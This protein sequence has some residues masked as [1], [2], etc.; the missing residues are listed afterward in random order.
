MGRLAC[1]WLVVAGCIADRTVPCGDL[2]CPVG[3]VCTPG[4]CATEENA[5][6]CDAVPD[7]D[8]CTT[9]AREPGSC[10]GGACQPVVC[11]NGVREPGE[12]CDDA[13]LD[14]GDGC[15]ATC[16]S[17]ET[18]GNGVIDTGL[19]EQCDTG[20]AGLSS[21]GCSSRCQGELH[22]WQE[23]TPQAIAGRGGLAFGYDL[24]RG[25]SIAFGGY[26]ASSTL[27]DTWELKDL[28]WRQRLAPV[29]P[30]ARFYAALAYDPVSER[31]LLFGGV[32]SSQVWGDTWAWDGDTWV[33]LAPT[34]MP[35]ARWGA[36]MAPDYDRGRVVLFGGYGANGDL[37]DTWEWD[38]ADWKQVPITTP[39]PRRS[40]HA[41]AFDGVTRQVVM[42]GG[43]TLMGDTWTYDGARWL[44]RTTTTTPTIRTATRMAYD[45]RRRALVIFGGTDVS[46]GTRLGETWE[47]GS[48]WVKRTP[49]ASPPPRTE[50][51]MVWD[52]G[53]QRVLV[54]GGYTYTSQSVLYADLW[55]YDGTTWAQV[56]A[57]PPSPPP[58]T[59]HGF[60]YDPRRGRGLLFGGR[61]FFE[62][63]N[64]TWQW[65][66]VT[67]QLRSTSVAP[68][69]RYG[70]ATTYDPVRDRVLVFGGRND[71]AQTFDDLW[72]WDGSAWSTVTQTGQPPARSYPAAAYDV[73]RDRWVLFGGARA[74]S[75]P[76]S[77]LA[78]T[79][80]WDGTTWIQREPTISP[81]P[82]WGAVA[83]YDRARQRIV[84]FGGVAVD[85]ADL[86]D[87][88]E[89]DG[90]TWTEAPPQAS[91]PQGRHFQLMTYDPGR[92]SVFMF[93]GEARGGFH[94]EET[95]E[96]D[97][98][99]TPR[100]PV[101]A[102]FARSG[103]QMIY[104]AILRRL[105]VFGGRGRAD[106]LRDT[107]S[108]GY[109]AIS[110]SD[111]RCAIANIDAD[112]D[113]LA[114]CDDP[115]CWG[116]C[117]PLCMPGETCSPTAPH[118][119]DGE[120]QL[121]EDRLLCPADC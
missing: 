8:A 82:R 75:G 30:P 7:G 55:A 90:T 109:D 84:V 69:H 94:F 99:W 79:W 121:T 33:A 46:L 18:C 61:S 83:V 20:L 85:N 15:S 9:D 86:A 115:D 21:D 6:A 13:N 57:T 17:D 27:G 62:S 36:A 120:C 77:V 112:G 108:L 105:V 64:D 63:Y 32:G 59:D 4:G 73:A 114:T 78:D 95:W 111:E 87:T 19:G 5:Y 72:A 50:L 66:G 49:S 110:E 76:D 102:A 98:T 54:T 16:A 60:V 118:C 10:R 96:F 42:F 92:R 26:G 12:A 43:S 34:V 100:M 45:E 97:G 67:W 14:G 29:A 104:D 107:I 93:G 91:A 48:D 23:I 68:A 56:P 70:H 65:D 106:I 35:P 22:A 113:G 52:Q 39:P 103:G 89:W 119:G 117:A 58:R 44:P 81:P 71:M 1:V 11:G 51:G 37:N 80:E 101:D 25:V 38:G 24:K 41:M 31:L 53:R 40:L 88:W 116:R 28:T 3:N 2:Q 47:L 74:G